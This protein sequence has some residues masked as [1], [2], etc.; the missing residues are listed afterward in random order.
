MSQNGKQS[1][2]EKKQE[3]NKLKKELNR[4]DSISKS[5]E[6]STPVAF[7]ISL[8]GVIGSFIVYGYFQEEL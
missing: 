3:T 2:S 8:L 7:F 6:L 5:N 4:Q 1:L